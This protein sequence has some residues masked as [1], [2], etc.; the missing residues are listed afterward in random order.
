M[1]AVIY[2]LA[3]LAGVGGAVLWFLDYRNR[4]TALDNQAR[5]RQ[6][7][8]NSGYDALPAVQ[9][10]RPLSASSIEV[11]AE[12][13]I[14]TDAQMTRAHSVQPTP[15]D[16]DLVDS[17]FYPSEYAEDTRPASDLDGVDAYEDVYGDLP[18]K[19]V[20]SAVS[21]SSGE[22]GKEG[23]GWFRFSGKKRR[24]RV[25]WVSTHGFAEVQEEHLLDNE[26]TRGPAARKNVKPRDILLG[27]IEGYETYISDL[28]G[29]TVI[30]M[31]R[32]AAS[33]II[34]DMVRTQIPPAEDLLEI[35]ELE[36]FIL[37][38]SDPEPTQGFVDSRVTHALSHLPK[39]VE[40]VWLEADW[41]VADM[42]K[43]TPPEVWEATF[44]PLALLADAARLLPPVPS[45]A[46]V[47]PAEDLDVSRPMAL[48]DPDEAFAENQGV[49][50]E[51]EFPE[52]Q[53]PEVLRPEHPVAVPSRTQN[54]TFG[55]VDLQPL[56]GDEVAP[57]AAG[58]EQGSEEDY[59]GTRVVR[60]LSRSSS[61]FEDL[62]AELGDPQISMELPDWDDMDA[63]EDTA[64]AG[65]DDAEE[66]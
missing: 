8:E 1:T 60:N 38:C 61:I 58:E 35:G 18:G 22:Q 44:A 40:G 34:V 59:Q 20:P 66:K 33:P 12:Q 49:D 14:L 13:P 7:L 29:S 57:I 32:G 47:L 5:D 54:A 50:K 64:E 21:D 16:E 51:E 36:G 37:S 39:E 55:P 24:E 25:T 42:P 56:G 48:P 45:A 28:G 2:T 46:Q 9:S 6:S 4:T 3:V 26:W 23:R 53:H 15:S 19:G 52:F 11:T 10:K 27:E 43:G 31:R 41:V 63:A 65:E 30:A 62:A 17:D